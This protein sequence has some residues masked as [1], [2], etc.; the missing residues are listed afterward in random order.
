MLS[1]GGT[2]QVSA[3]NPVLGNTLELLAMVSA[4][5][6][7]LA[8]KHLSAR[9]DAWLLTW[10]Q[11]IIGTVFFLPMALA[12]GPSTWLSASPTA[13]AC[14]A[15]LGIFVSLGAFGLYNSALA[16]LPASRAA[17]AINVIPAVAMLA[18]WLVLG[19]QMS[20][21][22][23][24]ACA[25]IIGAVIFAETG[26]EPAADPRDVEVLAAAER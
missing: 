20:A 19:E 22:Q 15:Y 24:V 18:G 10:M 25:V 4:A 2:A 11:A 5:G 13:W 23:L 9:Y 16:K 6:S 7:M 8:I 17:L 12:S 3:P 26:A 21:M 1:L 14:V